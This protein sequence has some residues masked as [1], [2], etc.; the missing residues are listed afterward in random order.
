MKAMILEILAELIGG[1]IIVAKRYGVEIK[2]DELAE[3]A[4]EY[5]VKRASEK[6][7]GKERRDKIFENGE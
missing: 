3:R 5:A 7:E 1:A 4:K 2:A 6:T